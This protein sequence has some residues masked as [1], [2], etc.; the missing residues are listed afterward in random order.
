MSTAL[1]TRPDTHSV[2][3]MTAIHL[4]DPL[5]C[6]A[7]EI[8]SLMGW[9]CIPDDLKRVI[10]VD[11]IGYRDELLGLYATCDPRVM[12]RRNSVYWWVEAYRTGVCDLEEALRALRLTID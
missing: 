1:K 9:A 8:L 3:H 5:L 2:A 6:E 10:A 11:L 12:A 7:S 4:G